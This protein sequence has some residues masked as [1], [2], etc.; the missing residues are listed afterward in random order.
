LES[1][2]LWWY[3][4]DDPQLVQL[5]E[6]ARIDNLDVLT[7]G[8]RIAQARASLGI[9]KS[10][11][12]PIAD[13]S[14]SK[15]RSQ[16]SE[17][18]GTGQEVDFYRVGLDAVWEWDLFGGTRRSIEASVADLQGRMA[19]HQAATVS[20]S[21]ETALRYVEIRTLQRRL[22]IAEGNLSAQ[23][24]TFELTQFRAQAGLST[25]LDVQLARSNLESTRARLPDLEN[26]L[27]RTRHSLSV[28]LGVPPGSLDEELAEPG[29]IPTAS[30]DVAIGVPAETLRRRPDVRSAEQAVATQSALVGVATAQLYPSLR[31]SGSIGLE[32]LSV[33]G[34]TGG[35]A[36]AWSFG[37]SIRLPLFN[38][39]K[40][41]RSVDV[42]VELLE[43]SEINYRKAVLGAW[44]EVEDALASLRAEQERQRA[45]R[46][47]AS[48]AATAVDLSLDLYSAGISDFQAVLEAQRSLYSFEDLLAQSQAGESASLIRL[49]KALGGGWSTE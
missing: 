44:A 5:V 23:L 14:G 6:R 39:G 36:S 16:S 15:T 30:P 46:E 20:V 9:S 43:Q 21:A 3:N 29:P 13:A 11:R 35:E 17:A 8:S 19:D 49:Y 45:Y 27:A 28:L 7:A 32:A 10:D 34:L 26:Q 33:E 38:R 25:E 12:W 31:L 4:F 48:A 18:V 42:Q 41:R 40:L 1:T 2:E 22:Q 24:E 37:P 47:A